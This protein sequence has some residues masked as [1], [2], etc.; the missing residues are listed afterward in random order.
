MPETRSPFP[1]SYFAQL[2]DIEAQNWWFRS[3]NR[4][5]LWLLRNKVGRFDDM[6]EVGCGTGYV[7]ESIHKA[8]PKAR[9]SGAEYHEEGLTFARARIPDANFRQL[10][11]IQMTDV[12]TYDV[13][14]A[15]DVIEHIDD[16]QTSLNNLAR[17]LR[18]GGKML[19]SVPQ[20]PWLWSVTDEAA[21]HVRRY[22]SDE[23]IDKIQR[24]GLKVE[25]KTSF[26]SFLVPL[27]YL[28]RL[29]SKQLAA[30]PM[31]ELKNGRLTT[32]LLEA[33]MAVELALIKLGVRPNVGGSLL[34]LASKA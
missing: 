26:V 28:S 25:Y 15:F 1:P 12:A 10:D 13:I 27:M 8:F 18:P 14:G 34:V 31:S 22:T 33:V 7:L 23:L 2:A 6:L 21:C 19:I 30:D 17:A 11:V 29:R 24:A 16:D 3:R 4:I 9:I 20:H 32:W 5:L